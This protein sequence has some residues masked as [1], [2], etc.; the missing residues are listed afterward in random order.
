[1][2]ITSVCFYL[3]HGNE[4]PE[5]KNNI[6]ERPQRTKGDKSRKKVNARKAPKVDTEAREDLKKDTEEATTTTPATPSTTQK[7]SV[8]STSQSTTTTELARP[9]TEGSDSEET[10][11]SPE[12]NGR[13]VS[14]HC[15]HSLPFH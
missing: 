8:S 7:T 9:T 3:G 6:V 12:N 14:H 4:E 13:L 1:M 11:E 10:T 2:L 5:R 15:H